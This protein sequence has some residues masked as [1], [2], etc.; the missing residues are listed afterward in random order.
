MR[1]DRPPRPD[2]A[3][4]APG[5]ELRLIRRMMES[6]RRLVVGTW[7]H[8]VV[9]ATVTAA[10]MS[11][12]WWADTAG[13]W[14][15][16]AP[17]WIVVSAAGWL[18]SYTLGRRDAGAPVRNGA[19]RS[20]AGIWIGTGGALTLL[21]FVGIASGALDP[22]A[23]PG[24][25]AALLGAGCV[26]SGAATGLPWLRGVGAVWWGAAVP[27]LVRPGSWCYLALACLLLLLHGGAALRLA[28][29]EVGRAPWAAA[30]ATP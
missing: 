21:G 23:F 15:A 1:P 2:D 9:W 11:G 7:H 20:F 16:I 12:T 27:L 26:A 19:T 8:Q 3:P 14:G 5:A 13:A 28:R 29:E 6:N 10:G 17:L 4:A 30:E 18:A 22:A 24:V 25:V